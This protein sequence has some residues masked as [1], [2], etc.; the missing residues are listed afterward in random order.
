MI[1]LSAGVY[2][3]EL[4]NTAGQLLQ[5]KTVK[6]SQYDQTETMMRSAN[7]P[8]GV[9]WLNVYNDTHDRVKTV[10]VFMNNE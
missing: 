9:Y 6:V 8:A 3:L 4:M 5:S 7:M 1:G 2:R 10:R